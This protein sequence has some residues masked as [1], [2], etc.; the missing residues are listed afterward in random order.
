[1]EET[2][3]GGGGGE[4]SIMSVVY[5]HG[6]VSVLLQSYFSSIGSSTK[7]S[8]SYFPVSLLEHTIYSLVF[9]K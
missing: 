1:M 3:L 2:L 6:L 5:L 4:V 9:Q 8:H 7:P